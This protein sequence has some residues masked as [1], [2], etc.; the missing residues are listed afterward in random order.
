MDTDGNPGAGKDVANIYLTDSY[1]EA[2]VD[3]V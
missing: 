2:I 1:E 3:F